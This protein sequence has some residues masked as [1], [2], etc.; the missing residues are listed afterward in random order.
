MN[1][2]LAPELEQFVNDKINSGKYRSVSEV[3]NVGLRLLW[4]RENLKEQKLAELK[5]KIRVGIEELNNGEGIDG[6]LVFAELENDSQKIE[7]ETQQEAK[8]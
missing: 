2:S 3:V 1:V 6:E 4:E 7:A 5:S 8:Q